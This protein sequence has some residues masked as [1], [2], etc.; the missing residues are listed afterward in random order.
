MLAT[1]AVRQTPTP[2]SAE[3]FTSIAPA[4]Y[5][6]AARRGNRTGRG[7]A[8][9]DKMAGNASQPDPGYQLQ[10]PLN[11]SGRSRRIAPEPGLVGSG[12]TDVPGPLTHY[13]FEVIGEW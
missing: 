4:A 8:E 10:P 11:L 12:A 3:R 9:R 7:T 2:R 6:V 13:E 1:N 5:K